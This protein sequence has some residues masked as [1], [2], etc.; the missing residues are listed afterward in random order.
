MIIGIDLGTTNSLA[1]LWRNGQPELVPNALGE[2]LTPSAVSIDDGGAVIV[3]AAA[4]D[5]LLTHPDWTA[6]SFKRAMGTHHVFRL[7]KR[8][9]RAEELSAL[10]LSSLRAD[11][12]RLLGEPV[13]QAI[14]TVPAYFGEAQR[15]ATKTAGHLAGLNVDRLLNEPTAAALAYGLANKNSE[16]RSIVLD[17]GGGTFDVS[18]LDMFEGVM[19]VRASA[20]DTLLGGNDFADVIAAEFLRVAGAPAGISPPGTAH[21]AH[22]AVW[23]AAE[24]AKRALSVSESYDMSVICN[25]AELHWTV[26]RDDL[27]RLAEPLLRRLRLPIERALRDARLDP[28]SIHHIVLA[29]GATRMPV[30]RRLMARLFQRLPITPINP[31][32]VVALGAAVQAGLKMRDAA[33]EDVVMTDVAPFSLGVDVVQRREGT[34]LSDGFY[35]PVIERN[36]VIPASRSIALTTVHDRQNAV[37]VKIYQGEAR[38]TRDNVLLGTLT[39]PVYP[40]PAGSESLSVRFTYDPSGLLEIDVTVASTGE[41]RNVV[42]EQR[43]GAMSKEQIEQKRAALATL[44]IHPRDQAENQA[45]RARLSRLYEERL[46]DERNEI[47]AMADQFELV[48]ERQEPSEIKDLREQLLGVLAKLDR[49]FFQ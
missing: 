22:P 43:P 28:A 13:T 17:L 29:G 23:R 2:V 16:E 3:G 46:G 40:A 30:F 24:V 47:A 19:E 35:Q 18:I 45:L 21:P 6:A 37:A 12:E 36:T 42:I 15:Q 1:A 7:G 9:F 48:L 38:M 49:S 27:E 5:R 41:T 33:L 39:V 8:Q 31:D 10:I 34:I 44:K 25:G 11:A 32:E 26:T 14:I 20:G 4:R